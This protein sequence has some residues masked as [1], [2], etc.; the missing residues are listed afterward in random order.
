MIK[1]KGMFVW[2]F[3]IGKRIVYEFEEMS[4]HKP[5]INSGILATFGNMTI[6]ISSAR[7]LKRL[8]N[9]K[10]RHKKVTQLYRILLINLSVS[11][12]FVGVSVSLKQSNLKYCSAPLFTAVRC[13]HMRKDHWS[14]RWILLGRSRVAWRSMV[15]CRGSF[16]GCRI[17]GVCFCD[18][19]DYSCQNDN[20]V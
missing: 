4:S 20:D 14:W 9:E 7:I 13:V 12:L 10:N 17:S 19:F 5:W 8:K 18:G 11:D 1:N 15:F 6:G 16:D 3:I 2:I